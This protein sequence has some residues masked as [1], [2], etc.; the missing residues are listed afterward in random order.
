MYIA[1]RGFV[2]TGIRYVY[3]RTIKTSASGNVTERDERGDEGWCVRAPDACLCLFSR[4]VVDN[5]S[6]ANR[7]FISLSLLA[8]VVYWPYSGTGYGSVDK[9]YT[10]AFTS[11]Q[12]RFTVGRHPT[13]CV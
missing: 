4:G 12:V 11:T 9:G 3:M 8:A 2:Y 13:G 10:I 7:L 1:V 6:A 5:S